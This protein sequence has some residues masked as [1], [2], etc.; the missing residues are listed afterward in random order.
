MA[1]P[2]T[3]INCYELQPIAHILLLLGHPP[4]Y[5]DRPRRARN[6]RPCRLAHRPGRNRNVAALCR[7]MLTKP[8]DHDPTP[9]ASAETMSPRIFVRY[10]SSDLN[11]VAPWVTSLA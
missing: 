2:L 7:K 8:A 9:S 10:G 1:A 11:Q 5:L 3:I 4:A 6:V